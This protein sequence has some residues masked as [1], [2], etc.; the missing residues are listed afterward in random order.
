MKNFFCRLK[1]SYEKHAHIYIAAHLIAASIALLAFSVFS[2]SN[3]LLVVNNEDAPETGDIV[4]GPPS[5]KHSVVIYVTPECPACQR[6]VQKDLPQLEKIIDD[7]NHGKFKLIIRLTPIGKDESSVVGAIACHPTQERLTALISAMRLENNGGLALD[8][9][10]LQARAGDPD[11]KFL[12][13]LP[14][15]C[16][17]KQEAEILK[18]ET[19][20]DF[21]AIGVIIPSSVTINH[22]DMPNG[23]LYLPFGLK[24]KQ[25]ARLM[26]APAA[27]GV[28]K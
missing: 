14:Q 10:E 28:E 25:L 7:N 15:N 17:P 8:D 19:W 21:I 18:A 24:T 4:F 3:T 6:L 12:M 20:K 22:A 23:S 26:S 1:K 2:A 27:T 13:N 5:A 16:N 9:I 11:A